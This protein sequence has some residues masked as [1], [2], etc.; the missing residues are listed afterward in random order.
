MKTKKLKTIQ[1]IKTTKGMSIIMILTLSQTEVK[2]VVGKRKNKMSLAGVPGR[3]IVDGLYILQSSHQEGFTRRLPRPLPLYAV[4][5][6][7]TEHHSAHGM[8]IAPL[9]NGVF[10]FLIPLRDER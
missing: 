9:C 10:P 7:V 2:Q 8:R 4:T 3:M 1:N 6:T 5:V